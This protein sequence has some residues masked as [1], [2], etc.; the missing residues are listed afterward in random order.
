MA[1]GVVGNDAGGNFVSVDDFAE[2]VVALT[3][4]GAV[5]VGFVRVSVSLD[6]VW[7]DV[8]DSVVATTAVAGAAVPV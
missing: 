7:T 5:L 6:F 8:A 1:C 2:S 3:S 4:I